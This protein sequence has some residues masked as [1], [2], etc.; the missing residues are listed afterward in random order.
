MFKKE[1][2]IPALYGAACMREIIAEVLAA[3]AEA[4]LILAAARRHASGMLAAAG[5]EAKQLTAAAAEAARLE[6][7]GIAAAA[8]AGTRAEKEALLKAAEEETGRECRLEPAAREA[9]V[10]KAAGTVLGD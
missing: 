4:G 10:R 5:A 8:L 2:G 3:E 1:A 6:A 7:E 9:A